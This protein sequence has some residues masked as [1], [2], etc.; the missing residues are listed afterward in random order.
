[1]KIYP[2][3]TATAL[4]LALSACNPPVAEYTAAEAPKDLVLNDASREL[5]VRFVPGSDRLAR[6]EVE[7]LGRL[8]ASGEIGAHDRI[9][10]S[11]SGPPSLAA[12]RAERIASE[13]L[14]YG[15]TVGTMPLATVPRDT[16]LVE[17]GRYLVTMP[18]CPNWSSA[19]AAD[20]T[21][22][23]TSN[24]GC[25]TASNLGEMVA[26]PTDLASGQPLGPAAGR[27][28]AAAVTRYLDDKVKLPTANT[29]LPIAAPQTEAPG[30]GNSP[31]S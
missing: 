13:M 25:A 10:V 26:S 23:R 24:F 1:M 11:P 27:P 3:L 18:P 5:V 2:I 19:A 29:S 15:L 22:M 17:I 31:G 21:N 12:R 20:F 9:S 8:V 7:R 6:G 16:A 4:L 14:R 28:A 30:A